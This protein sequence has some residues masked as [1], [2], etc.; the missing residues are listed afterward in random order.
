MPAKPIAGM[1]RSYK[2]PQ[3]DRRDYLQF[4]ARQRGVEDGAAAPTVPT[5][6]NS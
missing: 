3:A 1:A 5:S 4:A 2:C 6:C